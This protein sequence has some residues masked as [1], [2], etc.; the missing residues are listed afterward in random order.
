M[1]F[2]TFIK[3]SK[4]LSKH[5]GYTEKDIALA[6]G[7]TTMENERPKRSF[8]RRLLKK[9]DGDRSANQNGKVAKPQ[10]RAKLS[11][12]DEWLYSHRHTVTR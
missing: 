6:N 2:A 9:S 5:F 10:V 11:C 7:P 4:R 12:H 1:Q 3:S 8:L